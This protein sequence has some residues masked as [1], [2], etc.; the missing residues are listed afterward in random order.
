M[1]RRRERPA[2]LLRPLPRLE[3][4]LFGLTVDPL[5]VRTVFGSPSWPCRG[6]LKFSK[7]SEDMGIGKVGDGFVLDQL[8]ALARP[9][10]SESSRER[11]VRS[12]LPGRRRKA[13]RVLD[14]LPWR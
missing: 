9:R 11:V 13:S 3:L 6:V 8:R 4:I 2:E 7:S 5:T 10:S 14:W 1:A 12:R